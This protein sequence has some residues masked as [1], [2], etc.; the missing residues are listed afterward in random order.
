MVTLPVRA[1]PLF[2]ATATLTVPVPVPLA[3]SVTVSHALLLD[4]FHEQEL[5]VV[6]PTVV[7]SP[8][9]AAA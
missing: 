5:P 2:A 9:T 4:A 3:P 8:S 1:A 7:V 6:T